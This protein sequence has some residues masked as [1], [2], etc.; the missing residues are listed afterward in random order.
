MAPQA[1]S[2]VSWRPHLRPDEHGR[3]GRAPRGGNG[4]QRG[5]RRLRTL[6]LLLDESLHSEF[7]VNRTPRL[8]HPRVLLGV[9]RPVG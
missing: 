8:L 2:G 7:C 3:G 6:G 1:A 5:G 4:I 9:A